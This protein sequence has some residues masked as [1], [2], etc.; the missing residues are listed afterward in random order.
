MSEDEK[1]RS[2]IE[3]TAQCGPQSGCAAKN[4]SWGPELVAVVKGADPSW[5]H[6]KAVSEFYAQDIIMTREV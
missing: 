5:L 1:V 3:A 4:G 2:V 6:E